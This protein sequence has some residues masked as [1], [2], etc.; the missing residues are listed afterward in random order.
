MRSVY[1]ELCCSDF[2]AALAVLIVA[3]AQLLGLCILCSPVA[4][5]LLSVDGRWLA[6]RQASSVDATMP[7]PRAMA[8]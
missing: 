2:E 4:M 7:L 3:A 6:S 8:A 5:L 1:S